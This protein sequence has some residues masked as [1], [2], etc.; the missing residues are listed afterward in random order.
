MHGILKI[1]LSDKLYLHES[2]LKHVL[3]SHDCNKRHTTAQARNYRNTLMY[4]RLYTYYPMVLI[5]S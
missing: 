3:C 1:H 4:F 5:Q 2:D